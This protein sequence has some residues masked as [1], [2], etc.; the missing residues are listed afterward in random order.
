VSHYPDISRD[1]AAVDGQAYEVVVVGGGIY[2][3]LAA[4]HAAHRGLR[5][6]L[7]EAGDFG[8]ATSFNS[9][10]TIHG[11]LRYLQWLDFARARRS[12]RQQRW[13]LEQFPDLVETRFCL[14]PL[15]GRGGHRRSAFRAAGLLARLA[16]MRRLAV[17]DQGSSA[18]V[19]L[20]TREEVFRRLPGIPAAGLQG[21][22]LWQEGFMPES[23]RVIVECLRWA[24]DAGAT[25]LNYA[26]L[27]AAEPD[28]QGHVRLSLLDHASDRRLSVRAAAVIN[29]GGSQVEEVARRLGARRCPGFV[30]TLAW[31]L[32][33]DARLPDACALVLT[34]PRRG[35]QA[36]F[37]HP[38]HDRVLAGTGHATESAQAG[39]A[40]PPPGMIVRMREDF[41]AAYP[42]A[43]FGSARILRI[44]TGSL[45][46][47]YARRLRLATRPRLL[48]DTAAGGAVAVH[49]IGVKFTEAPDVARAAVDCVAGRSETQPGPRPPPGEHW[50]VLDCS[51]PATR[52]SLLD[53]AARESVVYLEDL[54]ERR[55]NAWCD[56]KASAGLAGLVH[57]ALAARGGRN[58]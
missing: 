23:S 49:V 29:A 18:L 51:P 4:V 32:L 55:T 27:T 31:N 22:A 46:G 9:L 5:T 1:P 40:M 10:R 13:W 3:V 2:G 26:E 21:A 36:Y 42:D 16:G 50:N 39:S 8:A 45:P 7:V 11:G 6:L 35:A 48:P 12:N 19:Q 30:P 24:V 52:E 58:A 34:P 38:F 56:E 37:L 44:L 14:M 57:G 17:D 15:Y 25:A 28:R 53:L 47:A 33:L 20:L 43:R 54:V 41:D